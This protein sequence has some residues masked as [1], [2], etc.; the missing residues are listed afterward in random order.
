MRYLAGF[1]SEDSQKMINSGVELMVKTAL[2]LLGKQGGWTLAIKGKE[3]KDAEQDWD[4][5]QDA[6]QDQW[7]AAVFHAVLPAGV[8]FLSQLVVESP[9]SGAMFAV[10]VVVLG[11]LWSCF[12]PLCPFCHALALVLNQN[13]G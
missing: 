11:S 7:L 10:L 3:D 4:K 5:Q 9:F 13:G 12:V 2:R 1:Y 8:F 6:T